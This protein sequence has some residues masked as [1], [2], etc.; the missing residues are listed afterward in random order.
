MV[1]AH[2]LRGAITKR[3]QTLPSSPC[4]PPIRILPRLV[5]PSSQSHRRSAC[6][7]DLHSACPTPRRKPTCAVLRCEMAA[8]AASKNAA[9]VE[10]T[11]PHHRQGHAVSRSKNAC[12]YSHSISAEAVWRVHRAL[13]CTHVHDAFSRPSRKPPFDAQMVL[14]AHVIPRSSGGLRVCTP[15]Y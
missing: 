2:E 15:Q 8:G 11:R 6:R 14:T 10:A 12:R 4:S 5:P 7:F 13:S 9:L 1:S 3:R